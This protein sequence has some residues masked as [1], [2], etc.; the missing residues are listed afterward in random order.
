MSDAMGPRGPVAPPQGPPDPHIPVDQANLSQNP[1][2]RALEKRLASQDFKPTR[3]TDTGH[4][5]TTLVNHVPD[6]V[7]HP[8]IALPIAKNAHEMPDAIGLATQAVQVDRMSNAAKLVK[9]SMSPM[10]PVSIE[11]GR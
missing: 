4:A 1:R 5:L 10:G 2:T 11:Q 7:N 9:A 6:L 3:D 8:A